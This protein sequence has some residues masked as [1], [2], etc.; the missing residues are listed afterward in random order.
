[1]KYLEINA[2]ITWTA[3]VVKL[4]TNRRALD[5]SI[6]GKFSINIKIYD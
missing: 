1:M 5:D 6:T 2:I 4:E 3:I